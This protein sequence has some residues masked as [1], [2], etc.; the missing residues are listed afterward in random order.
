M[1]TSVESALAEE[2]DTWARSLIGTIGPGLKVDP[3]PHRA[4]AIIRRVPGED[5]NRGAKRAREARA[6][7][8]LDPA[9]PLECLLST[10]EQRAGCRS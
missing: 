9:A 5:S 1:T 8:G 10:V 2:S 6:A 4:S 3:T 7:L